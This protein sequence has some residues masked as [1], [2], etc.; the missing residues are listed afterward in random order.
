MAERATTTVARHDSLLRPADGLFMDQLNGGIWPGLQKTHQHP[1]LH[2]IPGGELSYLRLHNRLLK[3]RSRHSEFPWLLARRPS[4]GTIR[5]LQLPGLLARVRRLGD[6]H[7]LEGGLHGVG[8]GDVG[9]GFAWC[10]VVGR[11]GVLREPGSGYRVCRSRGLHGEA[12]AVR[13]QSS[14]RRGKPGEHSGGCLVGVARDQF[15]SGR[16]SG[17]VGGVEF[18]MEV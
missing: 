4:G 13:P 16:V 18:K 9:R 7:S 5:R 1:T 11:N 6:G 14:G 10:R 3:P 12:C 17:E 15:R 2:I 8:L